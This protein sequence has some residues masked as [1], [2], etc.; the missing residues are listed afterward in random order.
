[1]A[2]EIHLADQPRLGVVHRHRHRRAVGAPAAQRVPAGQARPV[3]LRACGVEGAQAG[4]RACAERGLDRDVVVEVALQR[5][6]VLGQRRDV[7]PDPQP[8]VPGVEGERRQPLDVLDLLPD[9]VVQQPP[10]GLLGGREHQLSVLEQAVALGEV[11]QQVQ[12]ALAMPVDQDQ[13]LAAGD[14]L[15]EV[16]GDGGGVLPALQSPRDV[17][18]RAQPERLS[19]GTRLTHVPTLSRERPHG[20]SAR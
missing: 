20:G 12:A 6:R 14:A 10:V 3:R 13:P 9:V 1:M 15:G 19:E 16:A 2:A 4:G 18:A 11:A 5:V 7:R 17:V 8:G